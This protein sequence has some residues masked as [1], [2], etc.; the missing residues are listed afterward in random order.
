M[1]GRP[2]KPVSQLSKNL[3]KEEK[4]NREAVER[5]TAGKSDK[6]KPP[7]YLTKDQ[8]KIFKY[9][10]NETE[11]AHIFGNLDVYVLTQAAINI[12]RLQ[13]LDTMINE[14]AQLLLN[15]KINTLQDKLFKQFG[16]ICN[17]LSLSPQSRAKLAIKAA[18]SVGD[19]KKSI[20]E[21]LADDDE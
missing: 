14:D 15:S 10:K 3:T 12:D 16:R 4:E 20:L 7:A 2:A 5:I 21:M 1:A 11:E 8:K 19:K 9:I 18:E 17:E 13:K 6:L